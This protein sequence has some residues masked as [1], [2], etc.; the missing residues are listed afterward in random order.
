MTIIIQVMGKTRGNIEMP[1]DATKEE[2]LAAV[3]AIPKIQER[4]NGKT[5][6]REI[7]V[8]KRLVNLVAK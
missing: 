7:Y 1:L 2:I 6:I 8:P 3:K 5:I 4:L